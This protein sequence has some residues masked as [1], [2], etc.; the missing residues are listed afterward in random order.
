MKTLVTHHR[1]HLDDIC[2]IWLLKRFFPDAHDADIAFTSSGSEGEKDGDDP[3]RVLIGVGRG[4][5]DEHKGDMGQCAASLVLSFLKERVTF[6]EETVL[7]LD[8]LV[9][10]VRLEDTGM[11]KTM[12]YRE[13]S[14]PVVIRWEYERAGGDSSAVAALGFSIL[15]VLLEIRRNG[16]LIERDW[17]ERVEFD[18]RYGRAVAV[19]T[20]AKDIDAFA[21]DKGFDVIAYVNRAKDYHNI[22]ARAESAVDLGPVNEELK[23]VDGGADWF[24]HHSRKMLICGGDIAPESRRSSLDLQGLISLLKS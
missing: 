11:L 15:D 21:Y 10:W 22:K 9:E 16:V 6:D 17:N 18:S 20:D 8:A 13:Y 4:R 23:K 19:M 14:V 12:E 7:A 24:F 1:P 3:E 2:A 5:F